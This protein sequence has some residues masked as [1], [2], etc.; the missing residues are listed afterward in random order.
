MKKL[1]RYNEIRM[2][3]VAQKVLVLLLGGLS[4]G[5]TTNPKYFFRILENV[6]KDWKEIDRR[7]LHWAIKK[8][9]Q[10]RLL[11]AKDN[12]DG[13]T[14]VVLTR[15]GKKKALTYHIDT[16]KIPE[17]KKW[18]G[19]WRIVMFDIPERFKKA[20]DAMA[21][22]LKRMEF[23][24]LQK[25][26]FVHPFECQNEID[27]IIEFWNVRP[28]VRTILANHLDNELHVKMKFRIS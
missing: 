7:A 6:A 14:S 15:D 24:R 4:L 3:P 26:V 20:R 27:F 12:E 22:T 18:D 13:S 5:L 25:S 19:K 9:Y 23:Y 17:M 2:G 11:D 8:L 21:L 10:S 16:I 28:Y 1:E